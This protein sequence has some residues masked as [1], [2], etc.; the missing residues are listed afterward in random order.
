MLHALVA[1]FGGGGHR[2]HAVGLALRS[3]EGDGLLGYV[4][5]FNKAAEGVEAFSLVLFFVCLL[6]ARRFL[7]VRLRGD[8]S[9]QNGGGQQCCQEGFNEYSSHNESNF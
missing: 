6:F 1:E 4:H 2:E 9:R 3:G 5:G 7:V 8:A